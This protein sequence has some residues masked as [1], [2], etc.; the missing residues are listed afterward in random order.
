[1]QI[2]PIVKGNDINAEGDWFNHIKYGEEVEP[3]L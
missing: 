3:R 1:M 2:F